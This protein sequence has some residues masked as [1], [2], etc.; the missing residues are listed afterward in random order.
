MFNEVVDKIKLTQPSKSKLKK[1]K[2]KRR[3]EEA[4]KQRYNNHI[5]DD[6]NHN[7][8]ASSESQS[9]S[10]SSNL[11]K[12]PI[13]ASITNTNIGMVPPNLPNP[14]NNNYNNNHFNSNIAF[15]RHHPYQQQFVNSNNCNNNFKQIPN[16]NNH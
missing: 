4:F 9:I 2:R 6:N 8:W 11:N 13:F 3:R 1:L 5:D 14:T 12:Q 7:E 15:Q 10:Q 16:H